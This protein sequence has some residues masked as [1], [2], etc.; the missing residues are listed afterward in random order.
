MASKFKLV[1]QDLPFVSADIRELKKQLCFLSA[2]FSG[3]DMCMRVCA[4]QVSQEGLLVPLC[5][6][7]LF[8]L[9]FVSRRERFHYKLHIQEHAESLKEGAAQSF[10][11]SFIPSISHR[12]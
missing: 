4:M 8:L 10:S 9:Y 3:Y 5:F 11:R 2:W 12:K 1:H 7:F 6:C